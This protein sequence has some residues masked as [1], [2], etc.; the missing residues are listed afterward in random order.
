M[1][2]YSDPMTAD[3]K[4]T[5][6]RHEPLQG[7]DSDRL[8]FEEFVPHRSEVQLVRPKSNRVGPLGKLEEL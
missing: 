7:L 8:C 5:K 4:K 6:W 3:A 1:C 2:V